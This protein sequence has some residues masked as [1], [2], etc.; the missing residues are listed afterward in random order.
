[1]KNRIFQGWSLRS[2]FDLFQGVFQRVQGG[3]IQLT[4]EPRR[5]IIS[6]KLP[7]CLYQ[8]FGV[9]NSGFGVRG[10]SPG[11]VTVLDTRNL[12]LRFP[13]S[14]VGQM[15]GVGAV[16]SGNGVPRRANAASNRAT[17]AAKRASALL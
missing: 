11:T 6:D 4:A 9:R 17:R 3:L 13:N 14:E 12:L 1:M 15:F 8:V 7:S 2:G 5:V 16:G 10:G